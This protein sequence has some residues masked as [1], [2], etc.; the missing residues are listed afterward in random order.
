MKIRA[1]LILII[2][3]LSVQTACNNNEGQGKYA[4]GNIPGTAAYTEGGAESRMNYKDI[5]PSEAKSRL[6]IENEIVLLDVRTLEEYND[7][8]I[9]DSI[10]IP[11]DELEDMAEEV[12]A[13]RS[14]PIF[15][16]CR[17]GRRSVTASEILVNKGYK[18]VYNL[19]GIIDWPYEVEK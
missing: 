12:L 6:D 7:G 15:V 3:V 17:S 16:Y 4:K 9:P 2:S 8:H 18:N 5:S 14:I 10:L 13:D 1:V 11:V 19:G